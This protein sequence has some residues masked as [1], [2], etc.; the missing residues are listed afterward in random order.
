MNKLKTTSRSLTKAQ[1]RITGLRSIDANLDFGN[2]YS[3][4]SYQG[5]IEVYQTRLTAYNNAF[6]ALME[7]HRELLEADQTLA[8]INQQMLTLVAGRYGKD[9]LE[10]KKGGGT[11]MSERKRA[12]SQ[13]PVTDSAAGPIAVPVSVPVV[14]PGATNG[15]TV[16]MALN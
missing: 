6:L 10:Y 11:P 15:K 9:S 7:R 1:Q 2:N 13:P 14:D 16:P 5:A 3:V 4:S 8:H 12:K